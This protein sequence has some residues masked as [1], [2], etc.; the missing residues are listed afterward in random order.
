MTLQVVVKKL[1]EALH[2]RISLPNTEVYEESLT[3]YFT[4]QQSELKPVC[5]VKPISVEDVAEAIKIISTA[6]SSVSLAIRSGGH[7]PT[8]GSA[9]ID[10]GITIDLRDLN[11]VEVHSS[12]QSVRVG[13][14]AIWGRVY[15]TLEPLGISVVGAH[16][17]N[18][19][20][21]GF[22][23]GGGLSSLSPR[24]GFACDM[25]DEFEVV[26][27]SGGIIHA[28]ADDNRDLWVALKGGSNNFG[29]V[30][31]FTLKCFPEGKIWGGLTVSP[32]TTLDANLQA[33]VAMDAKWDKYASLK[34][35]YTFSAK[36]K[37]MIATN[38]EYTKDTPEPEVTKPFLVIQP[39]YRNTLRST[40]L[41]ELATEIQKL[42]AAST[43]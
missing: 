28:N 6:D 34:Q 21:G 24:F 4:T 5:I 36:T 11:T 25:V 7:N 39:F 9:N 30:T 41:S 37:Y 43:R 13:T 35:S 10:G 16:V 12:K 23:L 40:T 8:K 29:V 18:V 1:Q 19:G 38:I 27:A 3:S 15:E 17:Y 22:I 42:Q 26:L 2:S 33:L 14:G 20:V 32:M 31:C